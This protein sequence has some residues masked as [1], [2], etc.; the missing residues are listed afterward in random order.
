MRFSLRGFCQG[1]VAIVAGRVIAAVVNVL[2][3]PLF[4]LHWTPARYGEWLALTSFASYLATL[5]LGMNMAAVNRMTQAYARGD[6]HDYTETQRAALFFY[7]SVASVGTIVL[8]AFVTLIPINTVLGLEE[9]TASEASVTGLVLGLL[10][11]W[12]MPASLAASV[13]RTTGNL[14]KS[15]WLG[16]AQQVFAAILAVV[17]LQLGAG[18]ALIAGTQLAALIITT[19]C[20]VYSVRRGSP[21]LL[22]RFG[23]PRRAIL[24]T[25]MKTAI[26]FV[27]VVAATTVSV[28]GSVTLLSV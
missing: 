16:N 9:T 10:V 1:F 2:L 20:V 7:T 26:S 5:D 23:R 15:Q 24:L 6:V 17:A 4:L 19:G 14:S 13:F 3:V 22:P 18:V 12:A 21:A 11:L 27:L 8:A 25:L 28:Q